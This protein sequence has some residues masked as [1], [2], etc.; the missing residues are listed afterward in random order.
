MAR[1]LN[2]VVGIS[3]S[4]CNALKRSQHPLQII[5]FIFYAVP[6]LGQTSMDSDDAQRSSLLY[7]R[8]AVRSP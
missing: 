8:N 1:W 7:F 6:G 2:Q 3:E 4:V 5:L